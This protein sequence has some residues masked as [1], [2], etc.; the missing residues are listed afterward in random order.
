[1]YLLGL[2]LQEDATLIPGPGV[3]P[4][5]VQ[6]QKFARWDWIAYLG[7]IITGAFLVLVTVVAP[8]TPKWLAINSRGDEAR[9]VLSKLRGDNYDVQ[10]EMEELEERPICGPRTSN[11]GY[12]ELRTRSRTTRRERG[13]DG[14]RLSV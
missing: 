2:A 4:T 1:M 8:E 12:V 5:K 3:D 10:S 13:I 7:A 9:E 11:P 14:A 6:T